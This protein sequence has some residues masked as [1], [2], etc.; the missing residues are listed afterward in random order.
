MSAFEIIGGNPL[1]GSIR[2]GGAKNA[3]YKLMIA[4]LLAQTESRLLN[5]SHI[6]DVEL[7]RNVIQSLGGSV[8]QRGERTLFIDPTGLNIAE[9]SDEFGA[10]SRAAAR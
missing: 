9:I 7:T 10:A 5:F 4:S 3:S 6:S 8:V 2:L 1:Y